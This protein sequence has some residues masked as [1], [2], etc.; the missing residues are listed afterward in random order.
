MEDAQPSHCRW[1]LHHH[2]A[3]R[4][5]EKEQVPALVG[6]AK[7]MKERKMKTCSG[8]NTWLL[9][10]EMHVARCPE[11]ARTPKTLSLLLPI[12]FCDRIGLTDRYS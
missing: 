3:V 11:Y 2:R 10:Y 1:A 6:F 9:G 5:R 12:C 7:C 8:K 4:E